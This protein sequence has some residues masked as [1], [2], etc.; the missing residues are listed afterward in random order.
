MHSNLH[1][2]Q[3]HDILRSWQSQRNDVNHHK[4]FV[5]PIFIGN[6]DES[7]E[8]I[9]SMPGVFRYGCN[10][11]IDYLEPLVNR[12]GLAAVLLFPVVTKVHDQTGPTESSDDDGGE[13]SS[14]SSPSRSSSSSAASGSSRSAS[15]EGEDEDENNVG[16]RQP[17]IVQ[18]RRASSATGNNNNSS[19]KNN[20]FLSQNEETENLLGPEHQ[21]DEDQQANSPEQQS[22]GRWIPVAEP[23]NSG[24]TKASPEQSMRVSKTKDIKLI[25]G[26]ALQDKH[27]PVLRLIPKLRAKF[28]GLLIIC[29]VCLCA[30]TSTGH[31]CLFEDHAR[32]KGGP[33]SAQSGRF[34]ISN[35]LTC[36]YLAQLAVEYAKKGCDVVAPSDMM[37]GRILTIR[38]KLNDNGL[39]HV[40]VLSYSAKFASAFYGPFRQ[41]TDNAP[42]FGDRRAYQLPP[43]SRALALKAV[44]RDID[45]GADFVMV[46]PAGAY[47]DIVRDIKNEHPEVPIAVY[48]VSGEYSM[49]MMA[50]KA[51][52]INLEQTVNETLTAFRR[53]GSTIIITYFTP[54]IL[55]NQMGLI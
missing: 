4:D 11:A 46:K 24:P 5:L 41:A 55:R 10:S 22:V 54:D 36:Q 27:N 15:S 50:A 34:P 42:E 2:A 31:C 49:L 28:P 35:K 32:A 7:I 44:K 18:E 53:A 51:G 43:G 1:Q 17:I 47:L 14:T 37:D 16:N 33:G 3:S 25:K 21:V 45:Q 8:T 30:F 29:D 6:N 38:E 13:L 20:P 9:E 26:M 12:Y 19:S 40:S 39:N 48:Q 23:N 52:L